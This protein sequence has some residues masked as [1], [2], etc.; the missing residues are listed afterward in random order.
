MYYDIKMAGAFE[1]SGGVSYARKSVK[2]GEKI[3]GT[4][5]A[6]AWACPIPT[7]VKGENR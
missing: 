4:E 5:E 6:F 7:C 3:S 2:R 1:K